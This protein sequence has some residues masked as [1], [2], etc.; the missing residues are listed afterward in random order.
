[1]ATY[2]EEELVDG[3]IDNFKPI[4]KKY[5][6]RDRP[7]DTNDVI[8]FD[9]KLNLDQVL[10]CTYILVLVLSGINGHNQLD[11]YSAMY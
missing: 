9:K 5:K 3:E 2:E 8:D 11:D 6:R 7:L 4:F 10:F 1:M